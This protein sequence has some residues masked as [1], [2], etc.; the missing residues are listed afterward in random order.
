MIQW[1]L[2][3]SSFFL[4]IDNIV[5]LDW[6]LN[7]CCNLCVHFVFGSWAS[8]TNSA[9]PDEENPFAISCVLNLCRSSITSSSCLS[10]SFLCASN[11]KTSLVSFS[12]CTARSSVKLSSC[13]SNSS[14]SLR[15]AKLL[16]TSLHSSTIF[17][18]PWKLWMSFRQRFFQPHSWWWHNLMHICFISLNV[19]SL[20]V[21]M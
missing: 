8:K 10:L 6:I 16:K 18:N 13:S 15:V 2:S 20:K 14:V 19:H 1:R 12:C 9:S 3:S 4:I 17:S 11:S 21:Y 5:E 7:G